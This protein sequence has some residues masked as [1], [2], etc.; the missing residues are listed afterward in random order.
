MIF[1]LKEINVLDVVING[2]R[3]KKINLVYA[4]SVKVHIGIKKKLNLIK[5]IK[6][7]NERFKQI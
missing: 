3:E 6:R 2:C 7:K 4:R 5:M 1:L